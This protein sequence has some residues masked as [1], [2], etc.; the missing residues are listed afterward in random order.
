M[1]PLFRLLLPAFDGRH[2]P[3]TLKR[4]GDCRLP[5]GLRMRVTRADGRCGVLVDAVAPI[6]G[7][8]DAAGR[9][10]PQANGKQARTAE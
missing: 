8:P 7:A 9:E 2:L 5:D 10:V 4:E 1:A 6:G 3:S